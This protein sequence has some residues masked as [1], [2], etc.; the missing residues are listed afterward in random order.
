[1]RRFAFVLLFLS[2]FACGSAT[3]EPSTES[4]GSGVSRAPRDPEDEPFAQGPGHSQFIVVDYPEDRNVLSG[5]N[6]VG[7]T[8]RLLVI[9]PG[10]H[11][12]S[13]AGD[14]YFPESQKVDI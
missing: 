3:E 12:V 11:T 7:R 6:L 2:T 5:G 9:N 8:N 13:L 4:A 10:V 1:M 14:G